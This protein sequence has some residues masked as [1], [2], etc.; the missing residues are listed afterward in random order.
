MEASPCERTH[1]DNYFPDRALDDE[2]SFSV[3]REHN[4]YFRRFLEDKGVEEEPLD[5][6]GDDRDLLIK[7]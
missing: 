6:T 4:A 1:S 5:Y 2:K 7:M 3:S